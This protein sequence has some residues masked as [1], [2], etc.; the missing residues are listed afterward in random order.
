[1]YWIKR[2]KCLPHAL[3][4]VGVCSF[5]YIHRPQN[6]RSEDAR[7]IQAFLGRFESTLLTTLSVS[8]CFFMTWW[9]S[10]HGVE[11][12]YSCLTFLFANAQHR[13]THFFAWPSM[14][15]DQAIAFAPL[16]SESGSFS[17]CSCRDSR[18]EHLR[19]SSMKIER[20]KRLS[21]A[22]V[23]IVTALASL[24]TDNE[25][26]RSADARQTKAFQDNLRA[27]FSQFSH[28]FHLLL[29][30]LLIIDTKSGDLPVCQFEVS[31][32]RICVRVLPCC[33]TTLSLVHFLFQSLA[34]FPLLLRK[35]VTPTFSCTLELDRR[36]ICIPVEY[37]TGVLDQETLLVSPD[38]TNI[39]HIGSKF[40]FF[41]Q[42]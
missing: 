9:S 7:Q 27:S 14:S 19:Y 38:Q 20:I 1:M 13:F 31:F 40:S 12:S 18:L 5:Q 2:A 24:L 29:L 6:I 11:T 42:I 15:Y 41:P 10:I 36:T 4:H 21:Q 16:S 33:R 30:E 37:N 17:C 39:F 34:T 8:S 25:K 26:V 28:N 22:L 35:F 32:Q 23:H 3:V